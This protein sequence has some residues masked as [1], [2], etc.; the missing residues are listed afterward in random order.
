MKPGVRLRLAAWEVLRDVDRD[1]AYAN[2]ALRH[3]LRGW[4]SRDAAFVTELV[5]GTL[6]ALG[7][8]DRIIDLAARDRPIDPD[9]RN[10]LRLGVHQLLAM[11]VPDHA[12]ISE[13]VNLQRHV[14][15]NRA[16]GFVNGVL[17][18]ITR[19][20]DWF[21]RLRAEAP[22]PDAA[23]GAVHAH[24]EWVVQA[25]REALAA[26]GRDNELEALLQ[27][28][29]AP[30]L[31][32]LALLGGEDL[33]PELV[34]A[35]APNLRDEGP[36]PIGYVLER[37]DP[38]ES[39]A[40]LRGFAQARV[41]DQGSQLV[42]LALTRASIPTDDD[43]ATRP[44]SAA[45]PRIE[46]WIDVCAGPGGKTALLASVAAHSPQ[47]LQ[48]HLEAN[49]VTPH[50]ADL[51]RDALRALDGRPDVTVRTEDGRT[52]AAYGG[53]HFDRI[54]LDVPCTGLG[55]LR[56]RPEAR[57]R[58]T[59]A[60]VAELAAVQ[61]DLLA[62]AIRHTKPGGVIAYVTCSPHL[63]ET[64]DIVDRALATADVTLLDAPALLN[65]I[66]RVELNAATGEPRG[67]GRYAQLWPHVHGTDA[68]FLALLRVGEPSAR[69]ST[70]TSDD[71]DPSPHTADTY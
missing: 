57:W 29:N 48:V 67:T 71:A 11:R 35:L 14:G 49:E 40:Q 54:L 59:A 25:F 4:D 66:A 26:A 18:G 9:T 44:A 42:A 2:L 12:A 70:H 60:D 10:V 39:T 28:D 22:S 50:R 52:A 43:A 19:E 46:R 36:S 20:P 15:G 6:R 24:P 68:M 38:S 8:Y 62:T 51:V 16:T 32:H 37:G 33:E 64:R 41:Q 3:K 17:R 63:A 69:G 34:T 5:S 27:A 1:D 61:H 55:A 45:D 53:Q 21:A 56:R 13:S 31:V 58:K 47:T 7:R 23:L 65:E 30:P